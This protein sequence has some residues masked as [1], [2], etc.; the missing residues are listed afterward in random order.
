MISFGGTGKPLLAANTTSEIPGH[1]STRRA[2]TSSETSTLRGLAIQIK[3]GHAFGRRIELFTVRV[4]E[5]GAVQE[6]RIGKARLDRFDRQ[7]VT[8][9]AMAVETR[10]T[11]RPGKCVSIF[12]PEDVQRSVVADGCG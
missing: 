9:N 6:R 10:V 2:A 5:F 7:V 11:V 8:G 1:V 3:R 4:D 12:E